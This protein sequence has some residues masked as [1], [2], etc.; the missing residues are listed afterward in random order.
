MWGA[1]WGWPA[2]TVSTPIVVEQDVTA[3]VAPPPA[4]TTLW[5][6]CTDPAGYFPY[7]QTCNRAWIPVVRKL[8]RQAD[9]MRAR[10]AL[11]PLAAVL[12]LGGCA[13]VPSGPSVMALPGPQ[14]SPP[15]FQDDQAV[16]QQYALSATGGVSANDAAA[17][18]AAA[19]ALVGSA[20]G[21]AVGAILGSAT[22]QA[23]QGAAWGAGAGLLYGGTAGAGAAGYTYQETQRR[24]DAAY[25]QC[26]YSRGNQVPGRMVS[27]AVPATGQPPA[28]APAYPPRTRRRRA[29]IPRRA[30]RGS[31]RRARRRRLRAPR[32]LRLRPRLRRRRRP[33]RASAFPSGP[34]APGPAV[35]V[36]PS[37]TFPPSGIPPPDT[38]P[39]PV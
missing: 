23:G 8:L 26:M 36:T 2:A 18:S 25:L 10:F 7:V 34:I 22:G 9:A 28:Y 21:A 32:R 27:R 29:R 38:P 17:N 12:A 30:S 14:K 15:Q 16:C 33:R 3:F 35:P 13:T 4:P 39:P 31:R 5:Y 1:G 24:Y 11:L 19:S 20:L 37:G 6:Y